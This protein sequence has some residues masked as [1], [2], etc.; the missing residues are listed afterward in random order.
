[1]RRSKDASRKSNPLLSLQNS[2]REKGLNLSQQGKEVF[3]S[4]KVIN[5][6]SMFPMQ[7]E[8]KDCQDELKSVNQK[9]INESVK[10]NPRDNYIS[11]II[12]SSLLIWCKTQLQF[13]L[14][15]CLVW[16]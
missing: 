10:L 2:D 4:T 8:C 1:M 12:L 14:C 11:L 16:D 3:Q 7:Y 13:M 9:M 6:Q 15:H 5:N